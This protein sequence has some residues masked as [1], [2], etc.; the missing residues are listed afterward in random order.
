MPYRLKS[1]EL[2]GYK[3]FAVRTVFEFAES[4]TAIVGPNGSGK[5]NIADA[6]RWVLGEQSYSLLRG[7]KTEDMI[8]AG[9]EQR[10]RSGMAQASVVFDNSDNWLPIDFSEVA[11]ARRAYRDGQ[12]EYLLNGQRVRLKDISELLGESGLAERTYTIIGQGLVDAALAL[13]AE[14]RRRLFEEA[15]G[16]GLHR[17]RREESLRRLETTQRNLERVQDILTELQPRLRSLERQAKRTEDY[18][19]VKAD[20]RDILREWYGYHWHRAQRELREARETA[21]RQEIALESARQ[22][23]VNYNQKLKKLRNQIQTTRTKLADFHRQLAR[24]HQE[25][26][27]ISRGVAVVETRSRSL[28]DQRKTIQSD[29]LRAEEELGIQKDRLEYA[30]QEVARLEE[31]QAEA[32][33]EVEAARQTFQARQAERERVDLI[34]QTRRQE[35]SQ[36]NHRKAELQTRLSER[37]YQTEKLNRNL[38]ELD[39]FL[40]DANKR[41][42]EASQQLDE[43]NRLLGEA[44]A[45]RI[46]AEKAL[47]DQRERIAAATLQRKE[48]AEALS[49]QNAELARLRAQLEV[50]KQAE[51]ALEGYASGARILLQS[52]EENKLSGAWGT[53]SNL[54]E[55]PAELETPIAAALGEFLDGIVLSG[56]ASLEEALRILERRSARGALLPLESLSPASPL[57]WNGT[58]REDV[59]GIASRLVTGPPEFQ[60]AIDLLLGEVLVVR[61][62]QSAR[63]ALEQLRA[64]DDFAK[65]SHTV[66]VV[67]LSGEVFH[68]GGQILA[69]S[70]DKPTTL[71]RIRHK[72][73]LDQNVEKREQRA[74]FVVRRLRE[75]ESTIAELEA[76]EA[77]FAGSLENG[78]AAED[79]GRLSYRQRL[80]AFEQLEREVQW[81][82]ERRQHLQAEIAEGEADIAKVAEDGDV[83]ASEL[84]KAEDDLKAM[85]AA[86]AHLPVEEYQSQV[87]LWETR[88]AVAEH[89]SEDGRARLEDRKTAL[90]GAEQALSNYQKRLTEIHDEEEKLNQEL[91]NARQYE[92][93]IVEKINEIGGLIEP[94][95]QDLSICEKDQDGLLNSEGAA[96]QE[97]NHSE[98]RNAEAKINLARRQEALETLRRRIEDDFGLVEFEYEEDVSGPTPLPLQGLVEKLPMVTQLSPEV[99]ES[100]RSQRAHLKR[101]GPI[102]PEARKEYQEVKARFSFLTEQIADLTRAEA[103]IR[104]V[105]SELDALMEREFFKTFEEVAEEFSTIFKRIFGGGSARL[106]LSDPGDLTNTGIDIEARLPGRREQGL[107]LLSG[108]ERSLTATALIFALLKVS[109]TPFCILD[110]VDAM[111]DEANIGRY[112]DLLRELSLTTQFIIITHNRNTVQVAD[113]IYGVTMGRDSTSQ[114]IS[115]KLDEAGQVVT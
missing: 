58:H 1:L 19:Q 84:S 95:E 34:V 39:D 33:Q 51:L 111:L 24:L 93:E 83:L 81:R 97:L 114:V 42:Q 59:I 9:S 101:M 21:R 45:E 88:A 57:T 36:L 79:K 60:R 98:R 72:R 109:P 87:S 105:I 62:R 70:E 18:E 12:N 47:R 68:A 71:S 77:E 7:K 69:G 10:S 85:A 16:I 55:V 96:R 6:L 44:E 22:A 99:E 49:I 28:E 61:D 48:S 32:V 43:S 37:R 73:E 11:I 54:I 113:V 4:I 31:E 40:S 38:G 115:L 35:L 27:E 104:K 66:R 14:E 25:R 90:A 100:L 110:E 3:T 56:D 106:V 76:E 91:V 108:G 15:A 112:R 46:A 75:L 102:N 103:D 5:S 89:A 50:L 52:A 8:F 78:I 20:L 41:I 86:L 65:N 94:L 74:E 92:G 30:I 82:E 17:A 67:T 13:K 23:Q 63:Q 64:K 53:L 26:E 29:I 2:Q 80:L 107:S